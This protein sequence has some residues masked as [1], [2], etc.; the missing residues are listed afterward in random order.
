MAP[1]DAVGKLYLIPTLLGGEDVSRCVP[2]YN[3]GV[4][5]GLSH[6]VVE[7]IRSA[8]RFL[9]KMDPAFPIDDCHFE[10]LNEHTAVLDS[11]KLL[12]PVFEGFSI[13]LLSEAGL[14]CVADPGANLVAAAH[15]RNIQVVPLMG[16]S[17]V[18]A[19][20][21]A[22]GLCGQRFR[23]H[24]YLPR[25][26][27]ERVRKIRQMESESAKEASAQLFIETPYKNQTL[28]DLL[29]E[30]C[31]N[32]TRLCVAAGITLE[33]EYIAT[34]SV[35]DWKNTVR[36]NLHKQPALFILQRSFI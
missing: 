7:E 12:Q 8:R 1:T 18:F 36:P 27:D 35:R 4:I 16:A 32:E 25:E 20:L 23:F 19:A 15:D 22:S 29:L 17:S 26:K 21:M 28:W 33:E 34:K 3:R 31:Q 6:F 10:V 24:G 5:R 30:T 13:G 14:P 9:R 11:Q 2:E